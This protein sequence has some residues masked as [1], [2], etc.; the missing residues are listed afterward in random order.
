MSVAILIYPR[1]ISLLV[2]RCPAAER[3]A[4]TRL[5]SG[6]HYTPLL[7]RSRCRARHNMSWACST[8]TRLVLPLNQR[9]IFPCMSPSIRRRNARSSPLC[10]WPST[11]GGLK[12]STPTETG[13]SCF[14]GSLWTGARNI[15]TRQRRRYGQ[16][17]NPAAFLPMDRLATSPAAPGCPMRFISNWRAFYAQSSVT[18]PVLV[19]KSRSIRMSGGCTCT[20]RTAQSGRN[21]TAMNGGSSSCETTGAPHP[22]RCP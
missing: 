6:E 21:T 15:Q 16:A 1:L 14:T 11:C 2:P 20:L 19:E 9:E 3:L 13:M 17:F 4:T 18:A 5:T 7:I 22:Q 8:F 10:S 12:V